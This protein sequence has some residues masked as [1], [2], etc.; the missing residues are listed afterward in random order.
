MTR[1][2]EKILHDFPHPRGRNQTEALADYFHS[3]KTQTMTD[4][5]RTN[6]IA[7]TTASDIEDTYEQLTEE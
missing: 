6:G 3:K 5:A 7:P 2:I 4:A 1:S